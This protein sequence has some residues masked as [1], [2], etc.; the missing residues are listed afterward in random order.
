MLKFCKETAL[1]QVAENHWQGHITPD[2]S[3]AGV[4]NGGYIMALGARALQAALPH[5][6]PLTVSAHYLVPAQPGPVDCEV[7]VLRR[8]GSSSHGCVRLLQNGELKVLLV[9]V[10]TDLAKLQGE[11]RIN[12][13][14]PDIK[15]YDDCVPL[16]LPD[17]FTFSRQVIQRVNPE[18]V[19]SL[20]GKPSGAGCLSGWIELAD[21]A[22]TDPLSLL[23]FA[24][25]FPPPVFSLY[26]PTGWVPTLEL[27][28][29]V[30]G[31]PAPGPLQ[32]HFETGYL[33]NGVLEEDGYLWD[34]D[35]HLVAISR[36]MAKFRLP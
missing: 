22:T 16:P 12:A 26:G 10:F 21:G 17:E 7:E 13:A 18:Q 25:S 31:K 9:A 27:T 4:P 19:Q 20:A 6:D 2:W 28:V 36:Q 11:S 8:G 34:C 33:T 30:R 35:G 24:D 5:S 14:R 15:P 29:Q 32:C 3:I 23:L 1:E